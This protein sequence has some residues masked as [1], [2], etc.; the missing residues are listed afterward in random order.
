MKIRPERAEIFHA[1]RQTDGKTEQIFAFCNFAN[2][3]TLI[4]G[5]I[6]TCTIP[7]FFFFWCEKN[8]SPSWPSNFEMTEH[9]SYI[10]YFCAIAQSRLLMFA[11]SVQQSVEDTCWCFVCDCRNFPCR[12][13]WPI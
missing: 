2:T 7:L 3:A 11:V 4:S 6:C 5:H 10:L 8:D 9:F 12:C 13:Y 1:D